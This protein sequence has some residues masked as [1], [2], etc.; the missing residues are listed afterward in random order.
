MH[1][2]FSVEGKAV[3]KKTDGCFFLPQ[4]HA[5]L[6]ALPRVLPAVYSVCLADFLSFGLS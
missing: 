1:A 5:A 6:G 3:D 4:K 2:H